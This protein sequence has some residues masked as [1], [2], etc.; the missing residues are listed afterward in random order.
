MKKKTIL[1][2]AVLMAVCLCLAG[3]G[4]SG[5]SGDQAKAKAAEPEKTPVSETPRPA[6]KEPSY[7]TAKKLE[8]LELK[9][10]ELEAT[11]KMYEFQLNQPENQTD[12]EKAVE[13]TGL[14]EET[15]QKLDEAYDAWGE[16]SEEIDG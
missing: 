16:L 10:A 11:L 5:N 7:G 15:Q 14:Y 8:K 13:L 3:C 6:K 9:I 2:A 12:P 4:G 1:V